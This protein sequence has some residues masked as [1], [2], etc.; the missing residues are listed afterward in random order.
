MIRAI[1]GI[2][3]IHETLR[4]PQERSSRGGP[5]LRYPPPFCHAHRPGGDYAIENVR[6]VEDDVDAA[7]P[8]DAQNAPTGVWKSRTEREIP[9]APTS[10]IFFL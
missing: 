10:I 2:G 1:V 5:P 9:T 3:A 7:T 8:V 6:D 4:M